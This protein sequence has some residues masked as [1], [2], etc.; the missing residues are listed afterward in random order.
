MATKPPKNTRYVSYLRVSTTKQGASGL[1]LDAQRDAVQ[2]F[3]RQAAR[4]ILTEFVEV[5]SGRVKDRPQLLAALAECRRSKATLLI[6][7]L[8]RLA[9]NV[10]FVSSIMEAGVEFVATDAPFANRLMIHIL[11]AFAEHERDQISQ[12]TRAALAAAK[13]RGVVLGANGKK[14]AERASRAALEAAGRYREPIEE[15]VA[16]GARSA[17][18]IALGLNAAGVPSRSGGRWHSANVLRVM[19]RLGLATVSGAALGRPE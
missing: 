13:A 18:Q 17:R 3:A 14:L 7:K 10:A 6:A 5:E 2:A 9:R 1:G 12:R 19:R 16:A 4:D 8:D 11:A 15:I